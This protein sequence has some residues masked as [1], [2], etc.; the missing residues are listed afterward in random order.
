MFVVQ[1]SQFSDTKAFFMKIRLSVE[2]FLWL[3]V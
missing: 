1:A 2:Q 3:F